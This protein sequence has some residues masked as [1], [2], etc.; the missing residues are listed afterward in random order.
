MQQMKKFLLLAGLM[1]GSVL[2]S[3]AQTAEDPLPLQQEIGFGTNLVLGPIFKSNSIPL[4]F[5]YKWGNEK[6]LFRLGTSLAFSDNISYYNNLRNVDKHQVVNA[7]V[8]IGKEWRLN[9]AERWMLNYG[10]DVN[11]NFNNRLSKSETKYQGGEVSNF[12]VNLRNA[13]G[14]GLRPFIGVLLAVNSH[15]IIGTEASFQAGFQRYFQ[16]SKFFT[17]ENGE[18]NKEDYGYNDEEADGWHFHFRTQPASNIFVYY[19]F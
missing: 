18:I 8:F 12:N 13:Y 15:F 17:E 3:Q 9:M 5:I 11:F 1:A 6:R 10:G 19:R 2:T 14:A 4:D 16:K 7:E